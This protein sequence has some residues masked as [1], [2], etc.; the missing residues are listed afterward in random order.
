VSVALGAVADDGNVF[1]FDQGEVSVFVV[2]NFHGFSLVKIL[3]FMYL[4]PQVS[5]TSN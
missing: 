4:I 1:A 3:F 5:G 2:E